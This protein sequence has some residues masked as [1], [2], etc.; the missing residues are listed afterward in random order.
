MSAANGWS[1][2]SNLTLAPADLHFADEQELEEP[3]PREYALDILGATPSM[4]TGT[5][6]NACADCSLDLAMNLT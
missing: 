5:N 3:P 6:G 2:G 4:R 1:S